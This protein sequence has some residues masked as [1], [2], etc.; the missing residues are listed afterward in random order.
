MCSGRIGL[1]PTRLNARRNSIDRL[2]LTLEEMR[3]NSRLF[4]FLRICVH[5]NCFGNPF[6]ETL[7]CRI[8]RSSSVINSAKKAIVALAALVV[9]SSGQLLFQPS[10]A[11]PAPPPPPGP[12]QIVINALDSDTPGADD[13]EF[14]ELYDGGAGNIALD[15]LVVVFYNGATDT[16]YAAFDLDGYTTDVYGYFTLGN[17]AVPGVDRVFANG[18]LQNGAD[19]VAVYIGDAAQFPNGTPVRTTN[20]VDAVV[21]GTNDPDDPGLLPLL[22]DGEPQLNEGGGGSSATD[23]IGRCPNGT[24]GQRN[25]S[26]YTTAAPTPDGANSCG[27]PP[28]EAPVVI[29]QVYGAGGNSG[30][31]YRNDYVELFNRS[32]APVDLAGWSLQYAAAAGSGWESNLQPLGGTIGVGEY[33]LIALGSGGGAGAELPPANI[34]GFINMSATSGKIALVNSFDA[35]TGQCPVGVSETVIDFVG[36]GTANCYEG[37]A[38]VSPT[39]STRALFRRDDGATDT[40][41][42]RA[43]FSVDAAAPRRTAPIVELGPLVLSTNPRPSG[44]NAPRDATI[45]V[46]FTEPVFLSDDWFDITCASSGTHNSATLA[47]S[48]GGQAFYVTPNDNFF[49]GEACTVTIYADQVSDQ[50]DDDEE[51][52]TD[53]LPADYVWSFRV[54]SG[55]APPYP[56]SVHLTFG[57]P[58]NAVPD[59]GVPNNYLMEKPEYALSYD[60]DLGRP[61]WVSW[62]LS[63]D[64]V[65]TLTR[66]DSFRAD[67]AVPDVWYRVNSFDF[68]G[69]GF[70]RGHMVPNADRDKETSIPINQAVFLMSNMVAQAPG[71]NQG[72]WARLEDYLRTLLPENEIYIVSGPEGMGGTGSQCY[73]ETIANGQ[74]TV[75]ASTW[76]VAIVLP[77]EDGDDLSCV[78]CSTRTIAVVMPNDDNIRPLAWQNFV[79]TIDAVEKLT[80]YD[81]FS[82]LPEPIQQCIEG[83]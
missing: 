15:G 32:A 64:W 47:I 63:D 43:D 39:G 60:R 65:G 79:T 57:N 71:N 53:H 13:A 40:N 76:K 20:L 8:Q 19:A 9:V 56:P 18:L 26:T 7:T 58:S 55:T 82:N 59:I 42:N 5:L 17:A 29:S 69:T 61:N 10:Y 62:H 6:A 80:G 83:Q 66:V 35:L 74:V 31:A 41:N 36:Y 77:K 51:P 14:V 38:A 23:S 4:G 30:A 72:P 78:T 73:A 44:V 75:P 48:R 52:N 49:A 21:Y 68:A 50:D 67:P 54:S 34:D 81:F 16:S 70:D 1:I 46:T 45:Q 3:R 12:D 2:D 27:T 25:T 11:A 37:Q 28:D 22:N 24:G 33:Y